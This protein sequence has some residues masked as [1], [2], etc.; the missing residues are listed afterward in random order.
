MTEACQPDP[1]DE[2]WGCLVLGRQGAQCP[3]VLQWGRV[4]SHQAGNQP[5]PS[6]RTDGAQT[7]PSPSCGSPLCLQLPLAHFLLPTMCSCDS[8]WKSLPPDTRRWDRQ[9][10]HTSVWLRTPQDCGQD[11][12]VTWW[13]QREAVPPCHQPCA[14]CADLAGTAATPQ[15]CP[16]WCCHLVLLLLLVSPSCSAVPGLAL[17]PN[18]PQVSALVGLGV[19]G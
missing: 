13:R 3:G 17:P 6:C 7:A 2:S 11:V 14:I 1:S 16:G 10:P 8:R 12:G 19:V 9:S 18:L 4:T 15:R 5:S